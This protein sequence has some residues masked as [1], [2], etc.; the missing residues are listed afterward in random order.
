MD[1]L[2]KKQRRKKGEKTEPR[3]LHPLLIKDPD[4]R[5]IDWNLQNRIEI[6]EKLPPLGQLGHG[7]EALGTFLK[8]RNYWQSLRSLATATGEVL[9]P[10]AFRHRYAK[11]S[12]AAGFPMANICKAMGTPSKFTWATM[13]DSHLTVRLICMPSATRG[14]HK[15]E[16]E[17]QL[18]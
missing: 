13:Q 15:Y 3:Q 14:S 8:R 7:G 6:G 11:E 1:H 12:H 2:S 18:T 5:S 17:T 10:Y 9:K 4:G 16:K